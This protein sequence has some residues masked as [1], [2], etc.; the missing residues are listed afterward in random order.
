VEGPFE[1]STFKSCMSEVFMIVMVLV[2]V[3]GF[4]QSLNGSGSL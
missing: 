1:L 3:L 4:G 2:L